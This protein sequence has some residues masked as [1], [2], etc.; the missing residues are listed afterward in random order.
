MDFESG[1]VDFGICE[2]AFVRKLLNFYEFARK[3]VV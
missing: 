2:V 1:I 3:S